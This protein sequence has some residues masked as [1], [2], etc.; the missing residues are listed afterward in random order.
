VRVLAALN[1]VGVRARV[2]AAARARDGGGEAVK[3]FED[4]ELT[5]IGEAERRAEVVSVVRDAL[6][7]LDFG[8]AGAVRGA[9]FLAELLGGL[10][11]RDEEVAVEA[12]E[13]AV[14]LLFVDD[15]LDEVNG[16][17]V[18]LGGEARAAPAVEAFEFVEAVVEG[19]REVRRRARS[20]AARERAVVQDDDGL[21]L[22]RQ[23]VSRRQSRDACADDAHVR[24]R[25]RVERR[26]RRHFR[27]RHPDRSGL[28]R[29]TFHF[30]LPF[31]RRTFKEFWF[32]EKLA[33]ASRPAQSARPGERRTPLP[34]TDTAN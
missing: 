24:A 20:L 30:A 1:L 21:A 33:P 28:P 14:N 19:V 26:I 12:L 13:V 2:D 34:S 29:I 31:E 11:R 5:L 7:V 4:V 3:I 8:Q 22:S 6:D 27:R 17:R 25:V 23:E 18:A 15:L 16:R 10:A 9:E 32:G